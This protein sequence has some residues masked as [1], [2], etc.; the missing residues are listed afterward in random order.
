M[1]KTKRKSLDKKIKYVEKE[2]VVETIETPKIE[3]ESNEDT[4]LINR[5]LDILTKAMFKL[6]ILD[7][8][9]FNLAREQLI[10]CLRKRKALDE[11]KVRLVNYRNEWKEM[12]SRETKKEHEMIRKNS[13]KKPKR[14]K[15]EDHAASMS[16]SEALE[17][18]M[19]EL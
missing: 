14:T 2:E 8:V 7:T 16:V 3:L 6:T 5:V 19:A 9:Y 15:V 13:F 10:E 18:R 1:K 12:K 11:D 4:I 17:K